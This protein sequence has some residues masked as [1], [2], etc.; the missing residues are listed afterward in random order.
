MGG[1]HLREGPSHLSPLPG[2][3]ELHPFRTFWSELIAR[4][5]FCINIVGTIFHTSGLSFMSYHPKV[6]LTWTS[7]PSCVINVT[8]LVKHLTRYQSGLED[9]SALAPVRSGDG[10]FFLSWGNVLGF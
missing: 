1:G 9:F 7:W 8:A 3:T 5:D 10:E 6:M 2:V 4:A